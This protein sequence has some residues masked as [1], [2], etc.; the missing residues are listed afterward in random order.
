MSI[1]KLYQEGASQ[2]V[3]LPREFHLPGTEVLVRPFGGG[4]LLIPQDKAWDLFEE[5]LG[6]FSEDFMAERE[7]GVQ[8]GTSCVV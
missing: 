7:Q 6:E 2:G 1:A 4:L 5:S 3:V 8:G